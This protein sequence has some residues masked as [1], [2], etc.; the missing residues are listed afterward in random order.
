MPK[1]ALPSSSP[2]HFPAYLELSAFIM[3]QIVWNL[4]LFPIYLYIEVLVPD[5]MFSMPKCQLCV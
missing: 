3:L 2:P 1:V 5:L 4:P